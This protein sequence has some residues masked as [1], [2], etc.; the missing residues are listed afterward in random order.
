MTTLAPRPLV[1]RN[2]EMVW[3]AVAGWKGASE[4]RVRGAVWKIRSPLMDKYLRCRLTERVCKEDREW[5]ACVVAEALGPGRRWGR[6][7]V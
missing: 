1:A 2:E 4:T 7:G 3:E 6:V 5:M